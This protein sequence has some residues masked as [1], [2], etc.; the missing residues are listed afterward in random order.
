MSGIHLFQSCS[1][2]VLEQCRDRFSSRRALLLVSSGAYVLLL[3]TSAE[4]SA[5]G[6]C[7][8]SSPGR[9]GVGSGAIEKAEDEGNRGEEEKLEENSAACLVALT[10][11]VVVI[12]CKQCIEIDNDFS[13]TREQNLSKFED[14]RG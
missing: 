6:V 1:F 7:R 10:L 4:L 14:V 9:D 8:H 5:G 11:L 3:L 12:I 2:D 13:A